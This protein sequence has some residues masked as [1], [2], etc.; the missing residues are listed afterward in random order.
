MRLSVSQIKRHMT[1]PMMAHYEYDLLRAPGGTLVRPLEVG[2]IA[3][4]AL[5][6]KLVGLNWREA[7]DQA[8]SELAS[9]F[10]QTPSAAVRLQE[11]LDEWD[12]L[13]MAINAWTKPDDWEV[14]SVEQEMEVPVGRHTI[15]GRLDSVVVWNGSRWHLQHKTL[16][17]TKPV[18]VYAEQQR[19]DWHESVYQRMLEQIEG[20]PVAGTVLNLV[21]KFARSTMSKDPSKALGHLFLP[22]ADWEVDEALADLEGIIDDIEAQ[23]SGRR[24]YKNRSACAGGYGNVLCPYKDVCDDMVSIDDPDRFVTLE[25]RYGEGTQAD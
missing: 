4:V 6:A 5:A 18:A 9:K 11:T 15:V 2:T 17:A 19:T 16:A 23:G 12:V 8:V 20:A 13:S 14:L 1:C 24:I 22:R 21:R 3:H 10:G 7:A 25:S